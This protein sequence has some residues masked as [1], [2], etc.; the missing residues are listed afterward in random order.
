MESRAG[1]AFKYSQHQAIF[2]EALLE[3]MELQVSKESIYIH[4]KEGE[5]SI[6]SSNL[7]LLMKYVAF[8]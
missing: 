3:K 8:H 1:T 7:H 2:F 5:N 4:E 6:W